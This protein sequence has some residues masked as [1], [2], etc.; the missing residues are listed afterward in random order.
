[1]PKNPKKMIQIQYLLGLLNLNHVHKTSR[2]EHVGTDLAILNAT[3]SS[4]K[5]DFWCPAES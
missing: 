4:G 1:M 5:A 2:V 3:H